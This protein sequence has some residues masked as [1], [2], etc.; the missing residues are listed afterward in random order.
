MTEGQLA[1]WERFGITLNYFKSCRNKGNPL[2]SAFFEII[3]EMQKK[4]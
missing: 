4:N 1:V 2:L 3:Q